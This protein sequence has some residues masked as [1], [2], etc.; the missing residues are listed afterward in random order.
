MQSYGNERQVQQGE[1]W[2]LDILLSASDKE[3]IPYIV[4]SERNNPFFV[5]TV[6]STKFEKNLRYV[7]S[8]WSDIDSVKANG[9][10]FIPRFYQTTPV[11]CGELGADEEL[12]N[13]PNVNTNNNLYTINTNNGVFLDST[14]Q[15][16]YN[17]RY[18]YQY[19]KETDEIDYEIGHKP[20][21]YFYYEYLWWPGQIG[22]FSNYVTDTVYNM[23]RTENI[24]DERF[25]LNCTNIVN[26][27]LGR[28][29]QQG[30]LLKF[31]RSWI[32]STGEYIDNPLYKQNFIVC[33]EASSS[34]WKNA[35]V[36]LLREDYE[37]RVRYNFPSEVT[38]EWVGQNYMY[39]ITLV[40]GVKLADRLN[41][42]YQTKLQA[43]EITENEWPRPVT[44]QYKYVK[45]MWPNELQPDIDV[46][47]PLGRILQPEPILPPT[48]LEV[49]NNLRT[50]I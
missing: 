32:D 1:D 21:Y 14:A 13:C 2:N 18:L 45:L 20:Y 16:C 12:P 8:F 24:A 6:A 23:G 3:Y 5:T 30:D 19:I 34:T 46:D 29:P 7:K 35:Y 27:V 36:V 47:S 10:P 31:T 33:Y 44:E 28:A 9:D 48:K 50:I 25:Q 26:N 37:C 17:K 22:I 11:Y 42:I 41:Q 49:F 40:S 38:S 43:G 39:Q 15:D 4:S